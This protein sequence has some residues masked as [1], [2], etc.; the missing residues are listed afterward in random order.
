MPAYISHAIMGDSIYKE[1]CHD[2]KVFKLPVNHNSLKTY[3]LGIDL[4]TLAKDVHGIKTQD[5]LLSLIKYIKD[6]I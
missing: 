4:V 3:S 1:S 6:I 5:F 2:E